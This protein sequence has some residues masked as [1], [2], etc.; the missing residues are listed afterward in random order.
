MNIKGVIV[1]AGY[2]SRFLPVTKTIPKEMLP[3]LDKP[4]IAFIV[5]EFLASGIRDILIITSRR[6][7]ALEDFFDREVELEQVFTK[8]GK[9]AALDKISVGSANIFFTRQQEMNGTGH[10][11]LLAKAFTGNDPFV[12][13]YPDDLVFSQTPLSQQLIQVHQTTG[14]HVLAVKN[15]VHEDVSRYGVIDP[16]SQENPYC[17]KQL[18][19]KP[20]RGEEPSHLV[21]F[22]RYLF[23]KDLYHHLEQELTH[24]TQG[25]YYH[26]PAINA[27][28]GL[29]QV[30]ALDFEGERLDIGDPIG[31]LEATCRYAL[32]D[33]RYAQKAKQLF[34]QLSQCST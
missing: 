17:V 22:G 28:A 30:S 15:L 26:V 27:L 12:V 18:V 3:L 11:L 29:G 25:E 23:T 31:F 9:S 21:S 33:P 4:A 10:A 34:T 14:H 19:E 32:N 24:H 6:K 5:E 20:P 16:S 1:A 8:E 7:K 13:A 2:G